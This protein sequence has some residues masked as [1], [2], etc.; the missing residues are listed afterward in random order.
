MK[1]EGVLLIYPVV[2]IVLVLVD[3]ITTRRK[4]GDQHNDK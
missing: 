3:Y 2:A 4:N 1:G